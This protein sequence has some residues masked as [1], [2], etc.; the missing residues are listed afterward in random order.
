MDSASTHS[1]NSL[2]RRDLT[3]IYAGAVSAVA[4]AHLIGRALGGQLAGA[5]KVPVL[6]ADASRIFLLAAGKAALGMATEIAARL[7]PRLHDALAI[8]PSGP[9]ADDPERQAGTFSAPRDMIRIIV[10]AHPLPDASSQRAAEAALELAGRAGPG[11]LLLFALSGGAS[12]LMAAP[13]GPITLAD[14]IAINA[15]LLGSGASIRELNIVRRHLSIIKGGGLL[16]ACGGA[17]V[18]SL[19]LSDVAQ[20]DLAAIGSGPTAADPTTFAEAVGVLKRRGLWGR[21]PEAIRDRLERGAAGEIAETVKPGDPL[22]ARVDNLV[23][24]DNRLALEASADAAAKAGYAVDRWRELYGEADDVGRALSAHLTAIG[25]ARVCVVAGGEPVV[26]LRGRGRGG[27]AQQAALA[28]ALELERLGRERRII[29]LFAGTDG[30]DGPTDAAG[31]FVSPRTAE[32]AR[33]AGFDPGVALARN[34]AY[35]LFGALGDL[36]VTG[37]TGTNVSDIFIGLVNY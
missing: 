30:I 37:P 16:R 1:S 12:S 27:R 28:M 33:E 17:R 4:P 29:A 36:L 18:L 20:N 19:I 32:R 22:L 34:D 23:L 10:A 3:R 24:G 14:K 7:E 8:V 9:Q 31:A 25:G 15:A 6:M 35:P 21:A 13:A 2:A 26:T 5:E 11:D